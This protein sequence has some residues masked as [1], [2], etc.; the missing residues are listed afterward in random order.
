MQLT[1]IKDFDNDKVCLGFDN[2]QIEVESYY[3]ESFYKTDVGNA[4][5]LC[6]FSVY[7]L[8]AVACNA[9]CTEVKYR[10]M[11]VRTTAPNRA[12]CL[13]TILMIGSLPYQLGM[14]IEDLR[15][16]IREGN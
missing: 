12:I 2:F 15:F 16:E 6:E 9:A 11:T 7:D 10:G 4:L 8:L 3:E 5:K 14:L 13:E 1:I